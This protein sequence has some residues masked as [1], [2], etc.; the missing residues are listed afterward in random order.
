[1][2]RE[3]DKYMNAGGFVNKIVYDSVD[4]S[5]YYDQGEYIEDMISGKT[6]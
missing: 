2:K 3:N 1:M 5:P 4:S 6:S